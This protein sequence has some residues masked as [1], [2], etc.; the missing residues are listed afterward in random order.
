MIEHG[1][2]VSISNNSRRGADRV[3]ARFRIEIRIAGDH[4]DES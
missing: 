1:R 2:I 3:R 4:A